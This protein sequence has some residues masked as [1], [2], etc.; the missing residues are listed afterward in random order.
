MCLPSSSTV[1]NPHGK[2]HDYA[3]RATHACFSSF[4]R[5]SCPFEIGFVVTIKWCTVCTRGGSRR[6]QPYL[7]EREI[8]ILNICVER[9]NSPLFARIMPPRN[10]TRV[11]Q[12]LVTIQFFL[13]LFFFVFFL[14]SKRISFARVYLFI[15]FFQGLE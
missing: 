7:G 14:F 4:F 15:Y 12:R 5:G 1:S 13:S 9:Q 2:T 3:T 6:F 8:L 11:F 10:T